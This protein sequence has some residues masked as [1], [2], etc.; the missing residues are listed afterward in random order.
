MST[1]IRQIDLQHQE[2]ID[3]INELDSAHLAGEAAHVLDEILPRLSAYVL[4]HFG[5]EESLISGL[6]GIDKHI[7]KH[8]S[9]HREFAEK[10]AALAAQRNAP[11][12]M[13]GT[14]PDLA[15]FLDY[16]KSWLVDHIMKT[17]REL[18]ALLA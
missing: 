3:I 4:F 7:E 1:G 10:V 2:L 18:G 16:L 5:T 17:D 11:G 6:R 14:A 9:Q 8:V 15:P 13:P 12:T